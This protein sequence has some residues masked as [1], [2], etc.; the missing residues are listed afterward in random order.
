MFWFQIP[1][2]PL[3]DAHLRSQFPCCR[4]EY[5]L[6]WRLSTPS[7][8]HS[9]AWIT[10]DTTFCKIS[11]K[12]FQHQLRTVLRF[13]TLP[14]QQHSPPQIIIWHDV[15]NNSLTPHSSNSHRI[16]STHSF[17]HE[18]R[19]IPC[20]IAAKT[21]CHRTGSPEVYQLLRQ[22]F[23][24]I[25]PVRHLLSHRKQKDLALVSHNTMSFNWPLL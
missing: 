6:W 8:P 14:N 7:L 24:D 4:S 19:A 11:L 10:F 2:L 13:R 15:I 20:D 25:S 9:I 16:L 5:T 17:I 23:L 12:T 21:D 22:S 1:C 3:P 18:I